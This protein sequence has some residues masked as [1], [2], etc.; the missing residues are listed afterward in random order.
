VRLASHGGEVTEDDTS[1]FGI[2]PSGGPI[3]L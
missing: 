2:L 3:R 1:N